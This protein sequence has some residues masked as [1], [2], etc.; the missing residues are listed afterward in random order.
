MPPITVAGTTYRVLRLDG[1]R[2]PRY[3]LRSETSDLLGLDPYGAKPMSLYAASLEPARSD[4]NPLAR[5]DFFDA[6]GTLVARNAPPR[7]SLD[8]GRALDLARLFDL[9]DRHPDRMIAA[10]IVLY[11]G[12]GIV[13]VARSGTIGGRSP[14][15]A[16]WRACLVVLAALLTLVP[17][18]AETEHLGKVVGIADGDTFTLLVDRQQLRI[19]LAEIDTPEKGQPYG[20]RARQA[21]SELIYGKTVR[22]VGVDHDRYGRVVGRVYVGSIDVNAEMVRRGAAWVYRKYA[23]DPS[24]YELENE[25][26]ERQARHLGVAGDRARAAVEVAGGTSGIQRLVHVGRNDAASAGHR[27]PAERHLPPARLPG[28]WERLAEE[29]RLLRLPNCGG[30][31]RIP[32]GWELPLVAPAARRPLFPPNRRFAYGDAENLHRSRN[33]CRATA[34]GA[35]GTRRFLMIVFTHARAQRRSALRPFDERGACRSPLQR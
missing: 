33:V 11:V 3:L 12:L 17:A 13:I 20:N 1:S 32:S 19:R 15:T 35:I 16:G 22:V 30:G 26:R 14:V 31:S 29:P 34:F 25:A 23:K 2:G 9:P 24:L 5:L 8:F 27:E 7:D 4:S 18:A 6:D 10:S 21:L 28:L